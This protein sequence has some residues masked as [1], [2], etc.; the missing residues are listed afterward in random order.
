MLLREGHVSCDARCIEPNVRP[1][2]SDIVPL[3]RDEFLMWETDKCVDKVCTYMPEVAW[4]IQ[5]TGFDLGRGV[6]WVFMAI[7]RRIPIKSKLD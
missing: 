7:K 3:E 4:F 6:G 5:E 1:N 2:I